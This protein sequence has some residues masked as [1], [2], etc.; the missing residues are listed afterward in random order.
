MNSPKTRG[1][2]SRPGDPMRTL[3]STSPFLRHSPRSRL[4]RFTDQAW[5]KLA[6]A[7]GCGPATSRG[8]RASTSDGLA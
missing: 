2:H 1:S 3:S 4:A 8:V 5:E 6:P 7:C